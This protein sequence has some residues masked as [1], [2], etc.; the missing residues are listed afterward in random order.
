MM[1]TDTRGHDERQHALSSLRRRGRCA[2]RSHGYRAAALRHRSSGMRRGGGYDRCASWL[3]GTKKY[4][5]NS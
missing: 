2:R 3:V 4:L 1:G 5:T